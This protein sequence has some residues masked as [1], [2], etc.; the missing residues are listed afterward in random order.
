MKTVIVSPNKAD[1]YIAVSNGKESIGKT[2]GEAIDSIY[3]QLEED[4]Q[5]TVIYVQEFKGDEF[6]SDKQIERLSMLMKKWRSARDQGEMLP[7]EQQEELEKL[8]E[9]ELEASGKRVEK[10]ANQMNK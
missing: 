8:I 7:A 6:F 9:I 4:Q 10:I 1:R 2:I 3:D 5:N